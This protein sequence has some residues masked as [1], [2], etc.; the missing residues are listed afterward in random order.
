M[1]K[2]EKISLNAYLATHSR[3]R[4]LD[5]VIVKWYTKKYK[6]YK[7]KTIDE[8]HKIIQEFFTETES[9]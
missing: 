1:A 7:P 8:W 4:N 6:S 9:K 2:K 3:Q 5:K